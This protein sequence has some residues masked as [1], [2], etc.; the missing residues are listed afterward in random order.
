MP[1]RLPAVDYADC[2]IGNEPSATTSTCLP[3]TVA[4]DRRRLRLPR[5][6]PELAATPYGSAVS[7]STSSPSPLA[8]PRSLASSPRAPERHAAELA[9]GESPVTKWSRALAR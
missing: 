1:E 9:A 8:R 2:A 3:R 5:A 6:L 7:S 4:V